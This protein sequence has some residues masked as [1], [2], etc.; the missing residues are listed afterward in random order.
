M[1]TRSDQLNRLIRV[2]LLAGGLC[3]GL[4]MAGQLCRAEENARRVEPFLGWGF[5]CEVPAGVLVSS[6]SLMHDA[7][8]YYFAD[9]RSA[10]HPIIMKIWILVHHTFPQHRDQSPQI[11][12]ESVGGAPARTIRWSDPTGRRCRETLIDWSGRRFSPRYVHIAYQGLSRES[13]LLADQI[14]ASIRMAEVQDEKRTE[15]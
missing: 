14:I 13:G 11:E 8:L 1:R 4:V 12:T 2:V 9:A 6:E 3:V 15:N 5:R 10:K 7:E